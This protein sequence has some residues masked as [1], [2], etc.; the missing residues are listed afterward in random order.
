MSRNVPKLRFKGFEDE[1][2]KIHLSD[3]VERV[4]R[5]NKGNVTNRPLTISAQYGLVNQEEFFNKVVASKNLEGYY[6]LNNGEFAYN[7]SYSNGYPFGAIKRL[8][9]YK[10]GA[11]STLYICFKPKLNVDSDFLTQYF[12]SSKWYREVSMV[13]VEGAR[14]HG[15]LNIGVSDFFDTIHRFPSLQEQEKI[16]NFLSKVDSIIEKQEKKVEYWNSYKKG[17]MQKIFSQKIRFKD[18]NGMDYP[19][20]EKKNL[21]YVLSEISEK[22]KE[23]NQYEVL[24]STAN[25]VFK[26][27]EY[28][29]REIASAD[30]TG[31]KILRLNQ[32]VL[33]PQ[34]L[35]LGNI[36]YNNKYDMGI[37][38]PSYKIFNINKNLNEKYISYII[39]TDRML[40]GYK[41]ASE[42]GA[43]VVRR[44]LNMD[45][46][47]D[48]L[49]NIP[50]VEEQEKIA[51]FLSNIDNIIEKESKKLEELKQWK[52][53][54]LQQMFV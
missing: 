47:Y 46:F 50:C 6:L 41:Q 22:T 54:L 40:Y 39:K 5:K 36:N 20:W 2:E 24:S 26:Q 13:A 30:N 17:M 4:V 44:N 19:E 23:N 16:A 49:I 12:E 25:G 33:S 51:N 38:S 27:S 48:I 34:N 1:W 9:K 18:G 35:W 52:K 15:L 29:N 28:F 42:Q 7:K 14:N 3:R 43:S 10:N 21:K 37:V 11:V 53:G 45:L 8:D 31:Y 32:I